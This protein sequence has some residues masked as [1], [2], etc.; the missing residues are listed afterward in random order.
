MGTALAIAL[1]LAVLAAIAYPFWRPPLFALGGPSGPAAELAALE[2]R[3]SA[4][5]GAI[6]EVGFDLR[7]DKITDEDYHSEVER[8]KNEAVE[9]IGQI[10]SM[11]TETPRGSARVESLVEK[12]RQRLGGSDG[13]PA[14]DSGEAGPASFCTQCGRRA[15]DAD[16]FCAGCGS[17]L[18]GGP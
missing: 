7:T 8:L 18:K 3:K 16:R 17:E 9:V 2:T 15:G 4:I 1:L 10:E 5:Y 13:T 12:A 11:R 14:G 6:R